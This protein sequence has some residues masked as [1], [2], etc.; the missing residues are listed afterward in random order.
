MTIEKLTRQQEMSVAVQEQ[1]Q[2]KVDQ[3]EASL[4]NGSQSEKTEQLAEL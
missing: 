4:E 3:L 1:L 2:L